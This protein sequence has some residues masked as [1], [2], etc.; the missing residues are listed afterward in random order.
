MKL[1][2][3]YSDI[4]KKVNKNDSFYQTYFHCMKI[5]KNYFKCHKIALLF[6]ANVLKLK[7]IFIISDT[8]N[9]ICFLHQARMQN[10]FKN[11]P[12]L[13]KVEDN[14]KKQLNFYVQNHL[15]TRIC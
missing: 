3:E 4:K 14:K 6:I 1:R 2:M 8:E 12:L 10:Y 13:I 15:I 5:Y 9:S 7:Q 11:F